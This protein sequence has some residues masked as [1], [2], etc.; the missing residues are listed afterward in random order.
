MFIAKGIRCQ[1]GRSKK[2]EIWGMSRRSMNRFA[3][4]VRR[5]PQV[6]PA[7]QVPHGAAVVLLQLTPAQIV[8]QQYVYRLAVEKAR[9]SLEPPRYVRR[10]LASWN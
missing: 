1:R 6:I 9:Q 4:L 3:N 10:F 2:Q 7:P 5:K 8:W